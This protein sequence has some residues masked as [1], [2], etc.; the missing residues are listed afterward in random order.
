MQQVIL[1][2]LKLTMEYFHLHQVFQGYKY[3]TEHEFITPP[4]V[5]EIKNH[6]LHIVTVI[7]QKILQKMIQ[8]F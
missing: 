1:C 6:P 4:H 2:P 8:S 7:I 5:P 3:H